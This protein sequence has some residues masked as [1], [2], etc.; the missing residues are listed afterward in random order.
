M[1]KKL[2]FTA[3]ALIPLLMVSAQNVQLH[4]TFPHSLYDGKGPDRTGENFFFTTVE[5]FKPDQW[6]STFF[7]I[8]MAYS[9][10]KGGI[11]SAYWEIARD[12]KF[13]KAPICAHVEYNGGVTAGGSIPNAYLVGASYPFTLG[14]AHLSTYVVYK[15]NAF[16]EVSHDA[17]WTVTWDWRIFD[18]KLTMC[19]FMDL[20]SENKDRVNG[21]GGKKAILVAQ[22]QFWYN[23]TPHLSVGSEVEVS[24]NFYDN[25]AYVL[26]TAA[27]KWHF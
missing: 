12:L 1:M 4:Y 9:G 18:G 27:A 24:S 13:W 17:Q 8:D 5:M 6:G 11:N 23:I 21:D 22:P 16:E 25:G 26:P 14:T 19:G 10:Q 2:L 20:W 7:F 3:I 15:Y